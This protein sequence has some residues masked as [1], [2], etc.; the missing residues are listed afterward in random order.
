MKKYD[1]IIYADNDEKREKGL[2][3][4]EKIDDDK[5]AVFAFNKTGDHA[6][7]NK[8][9]S[10]PLHLAFCDSNG[11]VIAVKTMDAEQTLPCRAMSHSIK[12]V[13]ETSQGALDGVKTG[14]LLIIDGD[15]QQLYFK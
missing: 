14:D 7:W 13:V 12:Y 6:F 8:N 10:Y 1:I 5:C 11:Y 15:N 4:T 2:M 3:F 9:V